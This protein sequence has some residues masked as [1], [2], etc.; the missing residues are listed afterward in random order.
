MTKMIVELNDEQQRVVLEAL[1][2]YYRVGMGQTTEVVEVMRG[3]AFDQDAARDSAKELAKDLFP[4]LNGSYYGI[5]HD[6][7]QEK[8]KVACDVYSQMRYERSWAWNPA[9]GMT[10]DFQEVYPVSTSELPKVT[11]TED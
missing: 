3:S 5:R 1:E 8:F 2:L 7:V 6:E 11:V 10:V 4:D 9:G